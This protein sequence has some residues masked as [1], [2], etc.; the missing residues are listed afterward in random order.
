MARI[1]A[2]YVFG[3]ISTT[4]GISAAATSFDSPRL[5]RLPAVS[6]G[7]VAAIT[8]HDAATGT[9][10]IVH[11][12]AHTAAATTATILRGQEGS[13]A[14]E[15]PS[16]TSWLHGPTAQEFASIGGS[17]TSI[18]DQNVYY[19]TAEVTYTPGATAGTMTDIDATNASV[20]FTVPTS[21]VVYIR[22]EATMV[23]NAHSSGLY[24]GLRDGSSDVA[25]TKLRRGYM[26]TSPASA[27][28]GITGS[29]VLTG[30]TPG[31]TKTY[32]VAFAKIG[33]ATAATII[34]G[35]DTN[36]WGPMTT[37]VS[38]APL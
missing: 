11:V 27:H 31:A 9:Y 24:L 26:V 37:V 22:F 5:A 14:Q 2:D 1:H 13:T 36:A 23:I 34:A 8:L 25:K 10:E 18:L 20:T 32:K 21:G 15:W 33:T 35:G 19:P 7:D 38:A 16:G 28:I 4:D 29:W 12:T 17:S 30:L 6:G 3:T